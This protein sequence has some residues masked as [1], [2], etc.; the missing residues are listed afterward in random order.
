[1]I[2]KKVETEEDVDQEAAYM[3]MALGETAVMEDEPIVVHWGSESVMEEQ[4]VYTEDEH[5]WGIL[6]Q[7]C[8]RCEKYAKFEL[9]EKDETF[10]IKGKP[11]TV[12]V[13]Y[14]RCTECGDVILDPNVRDPFQAAYEKYERLYGAKVNKGGTMGN[15]DRELEVMQECY[16]KICGL[17]SE[18]SRE[19]A[20]SWLSSKMDSEIYHPTE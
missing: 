15:V 2:I 8:T 1:M 14:N 12:T 5:D 10:L 11:I 3:K 4:T 7:F 16:N 9:T 6:M 18:S 17:E 20:V 13:Q 19:R